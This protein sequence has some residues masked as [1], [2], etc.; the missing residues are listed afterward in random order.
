[1][2]P[3]P[4]RLSVIR[5]RL[6]E[7]GERNRRAFPWRETRDPWRLLLAE[8]LLHRTRADQVAP[9]YQVLVG[10]YPVPAM[11]ARARLRKLESAVRSLGL[12]WRVPLMREMARHIVRQHGGQVPADREALL[13]LPGVSDYIAGAVRALAFQQPDP[14]LDTNTV[15]VLGRLFGLPVRDSSRRSRRFRDLMALLMAGEWPG[16]LLLSILDLAAVLCRPR[17]P[18]CPRCPLRELCA[19]GRAYGTEERAAVGTGAGGAGPPGWP[20]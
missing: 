6:L 17:D 1:M 19:Y 13:A 11:M 3:D 14:V 7:W 8:V 15:R 10:R 18:A 9:V 16:N 2:R 20:V 5:R 4:E 12:R